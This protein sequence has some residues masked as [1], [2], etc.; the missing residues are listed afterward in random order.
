MAVSPPKS[1]GNGGGGGKKKGKQQPPP[2]QQHRR[3]D[4]KGDDEVDE[5]LKFIE[6]KTASATPPKSAEKVSVSEEEVTP[7][8]ASAASR[9]LSKKEQA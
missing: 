9:K 5:A 3:T 1:G 6:S 8:E 4:V 2:Q 7:T